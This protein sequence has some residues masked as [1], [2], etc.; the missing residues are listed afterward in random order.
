MAPQRT[1]YGAPPQSLTRQQ[2]RS[3]AGWSFGL[4]VAVVAALSL[5]GLYGEI[6]P[7]NSSEDTVHR[8][9]ISEVESP[10]TRV[11]DSLQRDVDRHA[12]TTDGQTGGQN[13]GKAAASSGSQAAGSAVSHGLQGTQQLSVAGKTLAATAAVLGPG[14]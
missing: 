1:S 2:K 10:T 4:P 7:L 6:G 14:R 9:K 13:R 12:A 5:F 11:V 8:P 3:I